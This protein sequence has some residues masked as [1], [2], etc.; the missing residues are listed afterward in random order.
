MSLRQPSLAHSS[1]RDDRT[2]ASVRSQLRKEHELYGTPQQ[3][4]RTRG[5]ETARTLGSQA[6]STA[7]EGAATPPRDAYRACIA[8]VWLR[9]ACARPSKL[10]RL[11]SYLMRASPRCVH[12]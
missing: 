3:S 4:P 7:R 10:S 6:R 11:M 12:K 5:A 1:K 8:R 2:K 9:A